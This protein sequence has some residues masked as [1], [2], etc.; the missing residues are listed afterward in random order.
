[1]RAELLQQYEDRMSMPDAD[2]ATAEEQT[3][4]LWSMKENTVHTYLTEA[5]KER[6]STLEDSGT[7]QRA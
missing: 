3:G 1:M 6:A 7:V 5:R 2:A 4:A